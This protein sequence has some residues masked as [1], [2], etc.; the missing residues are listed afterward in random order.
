MVSILQYIIEICMS[1]EISEQSDK[2]SIREQQVAKF[3]KIMSVH[4]SKMG[5]GGGEEYLC[6]HRLPV[7]SNWLYPEESTGGCFMTWSKAPME[8][9]LLSRAQWTLSPFMT[10][11]QRDGS[12]VIRN[13]ISWL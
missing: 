3:L 12:Q 7:F 6:S 2:Q 5:G 9:R 4:D 13:N 8:V 1:I 11:F 10:V